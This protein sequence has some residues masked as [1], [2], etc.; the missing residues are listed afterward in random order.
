ME[1]SLSEVQTLSLPALRQSL[2]AT[3]F[4][5]AA[6]ERFDYVPFFPE[7]DPPRH[8]KEYLL[9]AFALRLDEWGDEKAA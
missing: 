7:G 6:A 9:Y 8:A 3:F 2:V 4:D 1:P 5:L